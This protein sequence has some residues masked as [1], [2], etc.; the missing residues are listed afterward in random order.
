MAGFPLEQTGL[1]H[2]ANDLHAAFEAVGVREHF[3][4]WFNCAFPM[5]SGEEVIDRLQVHGC[6]LAGH[7]GLLC[8]CAYL[9][10][11]PKYEAGY[12]EALERLEHKLT[13]T[14]CWRDFTR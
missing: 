11:E 3:N 10:N 2:F 7:Y 4:P 13:A 5:F 9:P 1:Q 6:T 12:F 14:P 8:I